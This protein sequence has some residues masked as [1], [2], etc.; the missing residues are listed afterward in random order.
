MQ[1]QSET[2]P[3]KHRTQSYLCPWAGKSNLVCLH[4]AEVMGNKLNCNAGLREFPKSCYFFTII[5]TLRLNYYD[6]TIDR[7]QIFFLCWMRRTTLEICMLSTLTI[8]SFL[9]S[10]NQL[11]ATNGIILILWIF[12]LKGGCWYESR[13]EVGVVR[14]CYWSFRRIRIRLYVT[15]PWDLHRDRCHVS[16]Y[17]SYSTYIWPIWE[18]CYY[19]FISSPFILLYQ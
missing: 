18:V 9:Y 19:S 6:T 10:T 15:W 5:C 17:Q 11:F 3:T 16:T 8:Q 4:R 7:A 12:I 2:S 14:Y 13:T 1:V